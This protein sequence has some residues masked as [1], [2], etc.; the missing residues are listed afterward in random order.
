M[1][2]ETFTFVQIVLNQQIVQI[3]CTEPANSAKTKSWISVLCK[4]YIVQCI[5]DIGSVQCAVQKKLN[6][7]LK[8]KQSRVQ[9]ARCCSAIVQKGGSRCRG[10]GSINDWRVG[11]NWIE[12]TL[13]GTR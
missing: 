5:H 13:L 4:C 12:L 9:S 10:V 11:W 1:K 6:A 3:V 7:E 8:E 2:A